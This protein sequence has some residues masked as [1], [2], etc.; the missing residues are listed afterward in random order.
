LAAQIGREESAMEIIDGRVRLR[1]DILMAAWTTNL[2][3]A[4]KQYIPLYK[5]E[6]RLSTIPVSDLLAQ[7][8]QSEISR[9]VVSGGNPVEN[10]HVLELSKQHQEIIPTGGVTLKHG[11]RAAIEELRAMG[12]LGFKAVNLS[13]MMERRNAN[14]R[15][16][17]PLYAYCEWAGMPVVI[18]ASIHFSRHAYMWTGQPQYIDEVAV[19]FPTLKIIMSHGGN[20]FGP[21]VLAVAQRHPNLWLEFS[22]LNP[23][24][25]APEFVHAANTYLR[26]KCIFGTDYPLMEFDKAVAMWKRALREPVWDGF[27]RQNLLDAL[28]KPPV[29][30]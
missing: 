21:T 1:T 2:N 14:D 8:A 13:P 6:D 12:E 17:Y 30:L 29:P 9:V 27:F 15:L 3:P 23:E 25:M 10:A 19:D 24:Y 5:M 7:A 18:H 16:F 28:D 4:F 26:D 20:G 22:A 11:V